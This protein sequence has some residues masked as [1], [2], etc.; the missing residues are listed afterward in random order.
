[1]LPNVTETPHQYYQI[2][3]GLVCIAALVLARCKDTGERSFLQAD[4]EAAEL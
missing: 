1:M 4:I 3:W 2:L